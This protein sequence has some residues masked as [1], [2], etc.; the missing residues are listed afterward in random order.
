MTTMPYSEQ[1]ALRLT[2]EAIAAL[3]QWAGVPSPPD[4]TELQDKNVAAAIERAKSTLDFYPSAAQIGALRLL[5]DDITLRD[6][7]KQREQWCPMQA[8]ADEMPQIPYPLPHCPTNDA[9]YKR[10]IIDAI[11][12]LVTIPKNWQNLSFLSLVLE[13]YGFCLSH[14]NKN[15]ALVDITRITSA[16]AASLAPQPEATRLSLISGDLSGIQNFIYT[17]SSAGAL[18]SLRAR[19]FYLELVTEE[20]VQRLLATLKLPRSN[21]IYAGGGN[22][23]ILTSHQKDPEAVQD[24]Q[25]QFNHWLRKQFQGK[26]FLALAEQDCTI[27]SVRDEAFR[28]VWNQVIGKLNRQKSNKFRRQL[29]DVLE[30]QLSYEPCRVCHRDDTED[31]S[32]LNPKEPNSPVACPTCRQMFELG[33]DLFKSE[34]LV[35]SHQPSLKKANPVS[36]LA[37]E[38][39]DRPE[40]YIYYHLFK[41]KKPVVDDPEQVLLI[42]NWS[43]SDY[44]FSS[45]DNKTTPLLLGNYYRDDLDSF[46]T[47]EEFAEAA[48]RKGC[49]PRVGYLRMDV[50]R[51]GQIFAHGLVATNNYSL[52]RV[53]G[54][55]RQMSYFFKTYL[56]SLA[57]Y[58]QANLPENAI[59]LNKGDRPNLLF[60]YAGGD[61]LFVSGAWNEVTDFAFDVYQSFR[62]YTGHNPDIS[63]SGGLTLSTAK[64]PLYQSADESGD[65][66]SEAKS[67]GR[68]SLGMFGCTF[69]WQEW[70]G[71]DALEEKVR[72]DMIKV[73]EARDQDYWTARYS[74]P[75]KP[76]MLGVIP[77]VK[78]IQSQ[79]LQTDYSRNFVRNLLATAQLQEQKI[80]ELEEKRKKPEYQYQLQDFK[81]YLHLPQIAYTLA[82]LPKDTFDDDEQYRGFRTSLKSPYNAPY[83]RAI[84]TWIELLTRQT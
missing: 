26:I 36:T 39:G 64:Y 3:L 41:G 80:K 27:E 24:I 63:L 7:A 42:N 69:R 45:F 67:N 11:A 51:L 16:L 43:L 13:K 32:L 4:P 30:P 20:I 57:K 71:T 66:E 10:D 50:D 2:Q 75:N 76:T 68:D 78:R 60:I 82:R 15:V 61:D 81:Y 14:G 56:N 79:Q 5:F 19:S 83:F 77:F 31:L 48:K 34:S 53:A 22:L 17:I 44:Q 6:G 59:C 37:F 35:R 74:D 65:A 49:I 18:K 40:D 62:A 73:I 70:F 28:E 33:G 54:L 52:P 8:I 1:A 21:V 84:A 46:M 55:S 23:F 9:D 58:R 47:A 25:Y 72:N 12:P 29:N 38:I